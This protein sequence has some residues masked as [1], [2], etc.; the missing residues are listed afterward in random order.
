[1]KKA[2]SFILAVLFLTVS[3]AGAALAKDTHVKGHYRNDGTYVQPHY[4]TAPD[5][6]RNNNYSTY[7]NQNPYTGQWGTKPPDNGYSSFGTQGNHRN[8]DCS[9]YLYCQ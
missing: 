3:V 6:T 2:L 7:G 4:R 5:S 8:N 9:S 1:M